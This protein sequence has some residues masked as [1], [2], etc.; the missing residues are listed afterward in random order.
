[1]HYTTS[2]MKM[3]VANSVFGSLRYHK[4]NRSMAVGWPYGSMRL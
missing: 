3:Q 4:A 2:K 1:L